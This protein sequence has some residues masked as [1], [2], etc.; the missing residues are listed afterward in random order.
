MRLKSNE[1]VC[2]MI[3][4]LI[5]YKLEIFKDYIQRTVWTYKEDV[6]MTREC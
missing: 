3:K 5:K 1:V 4:K 6:M 2:R